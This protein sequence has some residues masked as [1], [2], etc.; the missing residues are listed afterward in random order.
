MD[1]SWEDAGNLEGALLR[2]W[3]ARDDLA[4]RAP[5]LLEEFH[6]GVERGG[7]VDVESAESST[8]VGSVEG[9]RGTACCTQGAGHIARRK[10][11]RPEPRN[12]S[13]V[14][15]SPLWARPRP[16]QSAS[17]PPRFPRNSSGPPFRGRHPITFSR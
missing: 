4:T 6:R 10:T 3:V 8:R 5:G 13:G 15:E 17:E 7:G 9:H 14:D 16:V 2:D 1:V 12:F 11:G